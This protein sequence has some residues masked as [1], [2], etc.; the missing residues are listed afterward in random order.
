VQ[1]SPASGFGEEDT[2]K[3]KVGDKVHP[4]YKGIDNWEIKAIA[5]LS[6]PIKYDDSKLGRVGYCPRIVLLESPGNKFKALWFAYWIATSQTE[7]KMKWG[8]RPGMYEEN[9]L[10]E[11]L[12]DA[13]RKNF[14]SKS[15]LTKLIREIDDALSK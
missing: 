4:R 15:F 2:M 14:F 12:Q 8:Q 3:A 10:L 7:G 1:D 13:F 5:E 6:G 11:L 9:V